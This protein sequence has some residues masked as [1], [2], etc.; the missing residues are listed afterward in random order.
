LKLF[1]SEGAGVRKSTRGNEAIGGQ[2]VQY[3]WRPEAIAHAA[4]FGCILAILLRNGFRPFRHRGSGEAD[5]LVSPRC[6]VK[7]WVCS[8]IVF[9]FAVFPNRILL[10]LDTVQ[11]LDD[12]D[13]SRK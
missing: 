1:I 13:T 7:A 2:G 9:G 8:I 6:V 5:M 11:K 4:V 3:V 12:R 10:S